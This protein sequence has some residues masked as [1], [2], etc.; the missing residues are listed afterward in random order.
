MITLA[1]VLIIPLSLLAIWAACG[2]IFQKPTDH[3]LVVAT[4]MWSPFLDRR[5][6]HF[7]ETWLKSSFVNHHNTPP[8]ILRQ[9]PSKDVDAAW[10]YMHQNGR[11]FLV[12]EEEVRRLG[13]D[14]EMTVTAPKEWQN[15]EEKYFAMTQSQHDLHCLN[16]V[17]KAMFK[18]YYFNGTMDWG[19]EQHF[20]HCLHSLLQSLQCKYSTDVYL[21][22]WVEGQD[23][24]VVDFNVSRKCLD[25]DV[26]MNQ[27][28]PPTQRTEADFFGLRAPPD[29][30]FMPPTVF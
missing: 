14:P 15:G 24:A 2:Q 16:M 13:K 28:I 23:T 7:K 20:L 10:E 9:E 29:A 27:W 5:E 26:D 4:N 18:D 11:I 12:T 19:T 6:M 30:K 3:E 8:S 22:S 1:Q 17:R 25:Y 21:A